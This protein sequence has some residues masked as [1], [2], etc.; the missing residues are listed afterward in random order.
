M[1][2]K[3]F[4]CVEMKKKGGELI[5]IK[6]KDMTFDEKVEYWK[7]RSNEFKQWRK[8]IPTHQPAN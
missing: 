6:T 5:Y 7:Q 1:K 3:T 2:N 8:E 4:D